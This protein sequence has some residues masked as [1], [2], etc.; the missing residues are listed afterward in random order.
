MRILLMTHFFPPRYNAGTENYTLSLAQAFLA[1]GH[2]VWVI[3]ADSWRTGEAY[4]NG[5]TED[6]YMGVS[7]KRLRLN[8]MKARDP[9][10]I[11]YQSPMVEK[12]L[13]RLLVQIRPEIVHVT[14]TYSLGAGVL[15]SVKS[16]SIPL[17]LTLMDFWFL[18]P[19][20]V[21]LRGDGRLCDGQTSPQECQQC[22]LASSN[23]YQ[24]VNPLIPTRIQPLLWSL[25]SRTPI[26]AR[27]RGARGMALDME[28]RKTLMKQTLELPDVILSHSR[29]VQHLFTQ[30]N[31]SGRIVHLPNG[32]EQKWVVNYQGKRNSS[33]IR[34]GYMG[35]ISM[36][37]GVHIL[38][39]AFKRAK[40]NGQACLGIWGDLNKDPA[41]AQSLREIIGDVKSISLRGLFQ[42][43]QLANV[44]AE[45]DVLVV[46]S[47]WFEN[48]PLVIQEAFIIK[49]PVIATNLG[50]MAEAVTHGV[51]GLLFE[52]GDVDDLARQMR[53][54][55]EEPNF[56]EQLRG[57]IPPVKTIAEE[58]NQLESIYR[59]LT[60]PK[61]MRHK[62]LIGEQ[63]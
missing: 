55:V 63:V 10:R 2:K 11:L 13:D 1:K 39:D 41:Y 25:V 60:N 14:S 48:A 24:R 16:A 7:V 42:R 27:L 28:D 35:Q 50:G 47:L 5:V 20:T 15:R 57:G 21:L 9:N 23:L 36:I 4:W 31:L 54:I 8:W 40:L 52:R 29:F 51:N 17:V 18:C 46:P 43:D 49:T 58:V 12:W 45:I 22:L 33:L 61:L 6:I 32:H 3:C 34:F 62:S 19:R 37:K 26:L 56:L 44:L 59:E 38:V 53:R 30:A